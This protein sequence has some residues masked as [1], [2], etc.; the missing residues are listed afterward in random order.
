[1]LIAAAKAILIVLFV[2][3]VKYRHR[4]TAV[5]S[6]ASFHWLGIMIALTLSN[7]LSCGWLE[8]RGSDRHAR[9]CGLSVQAARASR[10]RY[11]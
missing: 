10:S 3:H 4:L 1:M 6:I 9:G 5:I 8:I 11:K 7:H 2:M